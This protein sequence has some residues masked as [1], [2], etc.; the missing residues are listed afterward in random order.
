[1]RFGSI[2]IKFYKTSPIDLNGWVYKNKAM[3]TLK[4]LEKLESF[5]KT[6]FLKS[7]K[8]VHEAHIRAERVR[9]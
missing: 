2:A 1:M 9:S 8:A 7:Y 4:Y 5:Y 6:A 3:R